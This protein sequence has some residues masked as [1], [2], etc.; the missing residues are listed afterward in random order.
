MD[1][2]GVTP[3][4][5]AMG[6]GGTYKKPP[7]EFLGDYK[8]LIDYMH[9]HTSFNAIIIWGF[10][11]DSHGGV[12]AA[13]ELS[14]YANARDIRIIPGVGTSGYQGYYFEGEHKYNVTT[15]REQHPD[16]TQHFSFG[17]EGGGGII[18]PRNQYCRDSLNSM[19]LVLQGLA[20]WKL[21]RVLPDAPRPD[22]ERL[23]LDAW[24]KAALEPCAIVKDKLQFDDIEKQN[25]A[26]EAAFAHYAA[27]AVDPQHSSTEDGIRVRYPD[28]SW[29]HVRPSNTEPI[30]RFI[31]EHDTHEQTRA[32]V[33]EAMRIAREALW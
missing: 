20:Q 29:V 14:D 11:R 15:W 12:E 19:A 1:W 24:R 23:L 17:G 8:A 3:G 26:L 32:M 25:Q 33:D 21:R 13:R 6:G 2:A 4:G 10:L 31:A 5:T 30:V 7:G 22:D 28:R 16:D 18:D 9:E 27:A